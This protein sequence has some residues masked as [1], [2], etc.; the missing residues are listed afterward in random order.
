[1][2]GRRHNNINLKNQSNS[3]N[4]CFISVATMDTE[5]NQ[6]LKFTLV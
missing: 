4:N 1:M 6:L 5:I 3:L 2:F